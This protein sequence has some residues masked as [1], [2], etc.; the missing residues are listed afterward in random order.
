MPRRPAHLAAVAAAATTAA[1]TLTAC[2]RSG[3]GTVNTH[4]L[5]LIPT[6]LPASPAAQRADAQ[7]ICAARA[8]A[9]ALHHSLTVARPRNGSPSAQIAVANRVT[10]EKPGGVL[11]VPVAANPMLAPI[12][13]MRRAGIKVVR[14]P[15]P[16]APHT[17]AAQGARAVV[18]AVSAIEHVDI[19]DNGNSGSFSLPDRCESVH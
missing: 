11:I 13:S 5:V 6:A 2:G 12:L 15:T 14:L 17:A 3:Y 16:I 4:Q 19:Q 1:L 7:L 9:H 10:A 8:E 18:R